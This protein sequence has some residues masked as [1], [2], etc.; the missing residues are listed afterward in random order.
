MIQAKS[1]AVLPLFILAHF[2]H[3]LLTALIVPLLPYLRAD[4][5][6]SYTRAGLLVSAFALAYGISQLP[7]GWLGDRCD[8]RLLLGIGTA[9][10]A[11]AALGIGLTPS[12][13]FAALIAL[14]IL[15]G[16]AGGGYHPAAAPLLASR[17][18]PA[19]QGRAL[20]LHLIGGSASHFLTPLLAVSIAA[21]GGWRLSYILISIPVLLFGLFFSLT[22]APHPGRKA[23]DR[24][25]RQTTPAPPTASAGPLRLA[26]FLILSASLGAAAASL[27]AFLPL[28]LV[29]S[30]S[31]SEQAAA[32]F[33]A[34]VYSAGLWAAPLGGFLSDRLGKVPVVAACGLCFGPLIFALSFTSFGFLFV[35]LLLL[36]GI[37]MFARMPASE[38]FLVDSVRPELRSTLLGI[39]YFAGLEGS[40]L[41][42]PLLGSLIDRHGFA[43]AYRVLAIALLA[44]TLVCTAVLLRLGGK[45]AAA[46]APDG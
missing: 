24:P 39:Y 25:A 13:G 31:L 21:L 3:H 16:I 35:L 4:F 1:R 43:F 27:L 37:L 26:A 44:V 12:G 6:L 36:Y 34:M 7:A 32:G 33:L 42:T 8:A 15:M 45:R 11:A 38:A 20:G 5:G 10:V 46:E 19:R 40:G 22:L 28:F 14:L 17:L 9:G 23:G 41:I 30:F 2:S 29:D 18:E